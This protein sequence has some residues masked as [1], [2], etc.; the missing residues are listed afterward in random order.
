MND[1]SAGGK[2]N[3]RAFAAAATQAAGAALAASAAESGTQAGSGPGEKEADV[4]RGG[5]SRQWASERPPQSAGRT[6]SLNTVSALLF[7]LCDRIIAKLQ[8]GIASLR[9]RLR[10][11]MT[12]HQA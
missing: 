9:Q 4:R 11:K 6:S 1:R 12:K 7:G 2:I 5:L 3:R 10:Q 8:R